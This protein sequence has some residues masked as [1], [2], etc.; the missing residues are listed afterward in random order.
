MF[1]QVDEE[2]L[3][4]APALRAN[5]GEICTIY[6]FRSVRI[7]NLMIMEQRYDVLVLSLSYLDDLKFRGKRI[8]QRIVV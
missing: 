1:P 4:D 2:G 5:L 7:A 3:V 8:R 6:R